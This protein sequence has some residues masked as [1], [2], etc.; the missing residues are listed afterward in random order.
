[1]ADFSE[2]HSRPAGAAQWSR[3]LAHVERELEAGLLHGFFECAISC[4]V[5]SGG[6]RELVIRAGKS[7]KFTIPAEEISA[8][9]R[10]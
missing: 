8:L 9:T 3:A 4:E 6:R 1:M 7:H 2:L 10:R 5:G